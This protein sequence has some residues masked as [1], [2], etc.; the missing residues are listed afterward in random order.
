MSLGHGTIYAGRLKP[1]VQD[2]RPCLVCLFSPTQIP[3]F[4]VTGWGHSCEKHDSK[5]YE[6]STGG[7]CQFRCATLIVRKNASDAERR[8]AGGDA[9]NE[10][11]QTFCN[12]VDAPAT[13]EKA[14]SQ[15]PLQMYGRSPS[16]HGHGLSWWQRPGELSVYY[17]HELRV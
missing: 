9:T 5:G 17:P 10:N 7:V 6:K 14:N 12:C 11:A 3:R 2:G 16:H 8:H 15:R 13:K 1:R 4:T